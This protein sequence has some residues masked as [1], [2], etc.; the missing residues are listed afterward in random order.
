MQ[1]PKTCSRFDLRYQEIY[2]KNEHA[3]FLFNASELNIYRKK[4]KKL[5]NSLG[6]CYTADG[7][8]HTVGNYNSLLHHLTR[9]GQSK[10]KV[11]W[12]YIISCSDLRWLATVH[13]QNGAL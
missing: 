12:Q 2:T 4:K 7:W 6:S 1:P 3:V 10:Q 8:R 13:L 9:L 5:S 11:Y